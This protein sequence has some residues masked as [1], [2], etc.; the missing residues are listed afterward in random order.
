MARVAGNIVLQKGMTTV[1]AN[2][3]QYFC[4]ENPSDRSLAGHS[5]QG[6]KESAT[7][8]AIDSFFACGSSAPVRVE[9][10]VGTVAWVAGTL[11]VPSVQGHRLP[12]PQELWPYE[13]LFSSLW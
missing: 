1:L 2:T 5:P 8:C 13:S 12:Q 6:C 10:E 3:L 9:L 7:P 4:L 11:A